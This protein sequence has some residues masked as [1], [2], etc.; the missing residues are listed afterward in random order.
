MMASDRSSTKTPYSRPGRRFRRV[1]AAAAISVLAAVLVGCGGGGEPDA[2]PTFRASQPTREGGEVSQEVKDFHAYLAAHEGTKDLTMI[3]IWAI[4]ET[5][6]SGS[7]PY[8]KI[9]T[10]FNFHG[11][12]SLQGEAETAALEKA[13]RLA[14]AFAAWRTGV[15]QEHGT[16]RIN[17]PIGRSVAE[18][19]W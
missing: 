11:K 18:E 4:S 14:E 1:S 10:G 17:G 19:T 9:V 5:A 16:V 3:D 15:G 8:S 12:E 13:E 2:G 7:N 6:D